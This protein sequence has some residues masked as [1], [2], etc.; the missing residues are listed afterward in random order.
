MVTSVQNFAVSVGTQHFRLPNTVIGT[1]AAMYN[2]RVISLSGGNKSAINK[3][4]ANKHKLIIFP[5][6]C[7]S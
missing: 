5:S 7:G 1:Q 6:G 2:N 3:N 4:C